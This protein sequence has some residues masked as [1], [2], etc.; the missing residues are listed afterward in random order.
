M[1]DSLTPERI[2]LIR[3]RLLEWY[4]GAG[5]DFPWRVARD[6]YLALVAAVC[7][8]QTQ[9]ARVLPTYERWV[10]AFPT[11]AAAAGATNA[12]VLRAW[13]R[14]GYPRRALALRDASRI[15]I[16]RHG[17]SLPREEPALLALPGVGPFTAAIVRC[18]GFGEDSVAIDTNVVRVLGRLLGGDLQPARETSAREIEG[19]ARVL[20]PPGD[21]AR[22][23]P[24]L[25]DYGG[26]VCAARPRCN[27]CVV[28]DLC[29]ARPRFEAGEAAT[30]VRAQGAFGGSDREWRGRLLRELRAAEQPLPVRALLEASG[31]Q[32]A[33]AD[34]VR[35]L[36]ERLCREG[37]AWS[38][39]GWCGLGDVPAATPR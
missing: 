17:G 31:A 37:M 1:A 6:P 23:N 26:L 5:Q 24:A 13:E 7:A 8:Q 21:A 30:P 25:M 28:T 3:G 36:L 16:E 29:A 15:C 20:L 39:D 27:E 35:A 10:G 9:M 33:D 12:D 2:A 14:A 32:P 22:W 38:R 4:T 11:L 18:F 19:W 34:R